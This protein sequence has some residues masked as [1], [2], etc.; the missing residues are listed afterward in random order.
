M[1]RKP[2]KFLFHALIASLAIGCGSTQIQEKDDSSL[3][4]SRQALC[5]GM[6]QGQNRAGVYA[7]C[8]GNG[9]DGSTATPAVTIRRYGVG[10]E[11][12]FLTTGEEYNSNEYS[13]SPAQSDPDGACDIESPF[14]NAQVIPKEANN[15]F[16]NIL[17]IEATKDPETKFRLTGPWKQMNLSVGTVMGRALHEDHMVAL[18][19]LVVDSSEFFATQADCGGQDYCHRIFKPVTELPKL[20]PQ[21]LRASFFVEVKTGV[22][23]NGSNTR[24]HTVVANP[25]QGAPNSG[26]IPLEPP[27]PPAVLIK[28]VEYVTS[29]PGRRNKLL[30]RVKFDEVPIIDPLDTNAEWDRYKGHPVSRYVMKALDQDSPPVINPPAVDALDTEEEWDAIVAGSGY[31][32]VFRNRSPLS[33]HDEGPGGCET[34]QRI[35]SFRIP[36]DAERMCFAIRAVHVYD[37][38][39][40]PFDRVLS[41]FHDDN[42]GAP[43]ETFCIDPAGFDPLPP[44]GIPLQHALSESTPWDSLKL[45]WETPEE[46]VNSQCDPITSENLGDMTNMVVKYRA[47]GDFTDQEWLDAIDGADGW[48]VKEGQD[49]VDLLTP[50]APGL[51]IGG[52]VEDTTYTFAAQYTRL[53]HLANGGSEV[54]MISNHMP[55][56][57]DPL[58]PCMPWPECDPGPL[59]V[60]SG[61]FIDASASIGTSD[62]LIGGYQTNVGFSVESL[63]SIVDG[64]KP[65]IWHTDKDAGVQAFKIAE[66][67]N[68]TSA[69]NI[70]R[71][72]LIF[73][74]PAGDGNADL[75][76]ENEVPRSCGTFAEC[77]L[78]GIDQMDSPSD[79]AFKKINND[80][81]LDLVVVDSVTGKPSKV[82]ISTG[83]D[84]RNFAGT[85]LDVAD[86]IPAF[87][88]P[89]DLGA[90]IQN[91]EENHLYPQDRVELLDVSGNGVTDYIAVTFHTDLGDFRLALYEN[92]CKTAGLGDDCSGRQFSNVTTDVIDPLPAEGVVSPPLVGAFYMEDIGVMDIS[93][94]GGVKDGI[95]DLYWARRN[96]DTDADQT[97]PEVLFSRNGADMILLGATDPDDEYKF[98]YD[99]R[100]LPELQTKDCNSSF[101]SMSNI[102]GIDYILLGYKAVTENVVQVSS[103][104]G[105]QL[106]TTDGSTATL[107]QT[108][109]STDFNCLDGVVADL[110][111]TTLADVALACSAFGDEDGTKVFINDGST[112]VERSSSR[113]DDGSGEGTFYQLR[114]EDVEGGCDPMFT[115]RPL[116]DLDGDGE[117]DFDASCMPVGEPIID[118]SGASWAPIPTFQAHALCLFDYNGDGI[119]DIYYGTGNASSGGND[120]DIL[121]QQMPEPQPIASPPSKKQ[122][123]QQ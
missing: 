87:F 112:L 46:G 18:N 7:G 12:L 65:S 69:A 91:D 50:G 97:N 25:S 33:C 59:P 113:V 67:V 115:T 86:G 39:E 6:I 13:C 20:S 118:Y 27:P 11:L 95:G 57:T 30:M 9:D 90:Q 100:W 106:F 4:G 103:C 102:E 70:D 44:C 8:G 29:V 54:S 61:S 19:G 17:E 104:D 89:I 52:L 28:S 40:R 36:A 32:W 10:N 108:L 66:A 78:P 76:N 123:V 55:A 79:L 64:G 63:P 73:G 84:L 117:P 85:E 16:G 26:G 119:Q 42:K 48:H 62:L 99:P 94:P 1:T 121:V 2:A 109:A 83:S 37:Y 34:R 82:Y 24:T 47:G 80:D 77:A 92:D 31:R 53:N 38:S 5:Q 35:E 58:P 81:F 3:K 98:T 60:G 88:P 105:T 96:H 45:S 43:G 75:I 23:K 114:G 107:V 93:G 68:V 22:V 56:H 21:G 111:N 110:R 122:A 41:D 51:P 74:M 101:V 72:P 15:T 71:A 120:A 49:A 116:A 14:T